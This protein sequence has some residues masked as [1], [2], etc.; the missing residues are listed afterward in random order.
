MPT[1]VSVLTADSVRFVWR[2]GPG[3]CPYCRTA[4]DGPPRRGSSVNAAPCKAEFLAG[5]P[6][7]KLR[8]RLA[9]TGHGTYVSKLF[10]MLHA[11]LH[12]LRRGSYKSR[13]R[14]GLS[15]DRADQAFGRQTAGAFERS[16][17]AARSDIYQASTSGVENLMNVSERQAPELRVQRWIG[18]N[19]EKI[20]PL[21]CRIWVQDQRSCLLSRT[22]AV[23]G[24]SHGFPTLQALHAVLSDQG[25]GF[26]VIQTV[27]EGAHENT[28]ERLRPNQLEYE[29]P[30]AFGHDEP[31]P[32]RRFPRSCRTTEP[33]ARP[34][35]RSSTRAGASSSRTSA[36]MWVSS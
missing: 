30:V 8:H 32:A 14:L 4:P 33:V 7:A 5:A 15:A 9:A 25:V 29:L 19:G 2:Y 3:E 13:A 23:A 27:F 26:A 22:G 34:G 24:H 12:S 18:A 11:Y 31:R 35:S 28:F 6:L 17:G 36:W 1:P 21:S 10:Q 16:A 20:A